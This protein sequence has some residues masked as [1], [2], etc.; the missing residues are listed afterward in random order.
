MIGKR[1]VG[2]SV[3]LGVC[4]QATVDRTVSK[5]RIVRIVSHIKLGTHFLQARFNE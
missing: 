4:E 2:I 3:A 1:A 5:V